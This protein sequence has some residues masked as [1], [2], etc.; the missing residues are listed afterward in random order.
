VVYEISGIEEHSK[1]FLNYCELE[2]FKPRH[3]III[4]TKNNYDGS[5]SITINGKHKTQLSE[6]TGKK[7]F[8]KV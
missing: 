5:M 2:G 8:V 4:N 7:I 3:T 1:S 6:L